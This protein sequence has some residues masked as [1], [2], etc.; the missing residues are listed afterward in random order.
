M[1]G[2]YAVLE[3]DRKKRR[4][5]VFDGLPLPLQTWNRHI[6]NVLQR[7]NLVP[8]DASIRFVKQSKLYLCVDGVPDLT[9]E[10]TNLV[11]Q[12]DGYNC[13]PIACLKVWKTFTPGDIAPELSQTAKGN[14]PD[15][16]YAMDESTAGDAAAQAAARRNRK[17]EVE[18]AP[19]EV[20]RARVNRKKRTGNN[21]PRTPRKSP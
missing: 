20:N 14:S 19:V 11:P 3:I 1:D 12:K 9:I 5:F 4:V 6:V 13:G 10:S 15:V 16:E 18:A 7:T 8:L 2:H 21:Q 17:E